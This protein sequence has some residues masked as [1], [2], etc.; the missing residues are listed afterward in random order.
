MIPLVMEVGIGDPI[1]NGP[2]EKCS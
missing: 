1:H 2:T